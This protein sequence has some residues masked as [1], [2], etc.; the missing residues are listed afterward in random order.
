MASLDESM[1]LSWYII[2]F[3]VISVLSSYS[4]DKLDFHSLDFFEAQTRESIRTD[5]TEV[6][7]VGE[8]TAGGAEDLEIGFLWSIGMTELDFEQTDV[9]SI[10]IERVT[11]A[12][13]FIY[14]ATLEDLCE[15]DEVYYYRAFVKTKDRLSL[16][17]IDSFDLKDG[18]IFQMI[19]ATFNSNQNS[20]NLEAVVLG[21]EELGQQ[22]NDHGFLLKASQG[23][24]IFEVGTPGVFQISLG[25]LNDDGS[26]FASTSG[27]RYNTIYQSKAYLKVGGKYL[28]S[29][30]TAGFSLKDGWQ[31]LD[32]I[33][34][35]KFYNNVVTVLAGKAYFMTGCSSSECNLYA[36]GITTEAIKET[37]ELNPTG[38]LRKL[39][40]F[41]GPVRE[42]AISFSLLDKI[43]TGLGSISRGGS[44]S[45]YYFKD[46]WEFDPNAG[47]EGQGDWRKVKTFPGAGREGAVAFTIGNRAYVGT[48]RSS[49]S[50][51]GYHDDFFIFTPPVSP[52]DSGQW[53]LVE[54]RLPFKADPDTPIRTAGR[55]ES[56]AF[57]YNNRGYLGM[58][59]VAS[60]ESGLRDTNDFWEFDETAGWRFVTFIGDQDEARNSAVGFII[61]SRGYIGTGQKGYESLKDFQSDIWEIDMEQL[62]KGWMRK[63]GLPDLLGSRRTK[64]MGF[65][66]NGK[67][68]IGGG[69]VSFAGRTEVI[70]DFWEYTPEN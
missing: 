42:N 43:Y 21:L 39:S 5:I 68:I 37:W 65:A 34:I 64:A 70:T 67:G 57:S 45:L 40:P 52:S 6:R 20:T 59:E 27:L 36:G 26:F 10:R 63:V 30:N 24:D 47:S 12:E 19:N 7:L 22:T 48:G 4:C 25:E 3:S 41:P 53:N 29:S 56:V 38:E 1:K 15:F 33:A 51:S 13:S 58:G 18:F 17:T 32:D 8:V 2:S 46:F 61:D 50:L 14:T 54:H 9:N 11:S 44:T 69:L 60:A 66:L 35:G 23:T 55:Y 16:G 31:N 49:P 62:E 28:L